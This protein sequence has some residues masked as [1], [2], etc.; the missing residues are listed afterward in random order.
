MEYHWAMKKDEVM[1]VLETQ[2]A[3]ETTTLWSV[4]KTKIMGCHLCVKPK[5]WH[6][7]TYLW[8]KNRFTDI[9][10]RP[11]VAKVEAGG[12]GI[13]WEFETKRYEL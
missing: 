7:W 13:D 3:P 8:N 6:K 1:P 12:G 4:T 5:L 9:V 10:N 2:M 11:V